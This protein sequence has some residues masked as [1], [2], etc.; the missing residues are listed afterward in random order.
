MKIVM[1]AS[2]FSCLFLTCLMT[3]SGCASPGGAGK[4]TE[5]MN[6][7]S[8]VSISL[9]EFAPGGM[10]ND[11]KLGADASK[12]VLLG[13]YSG[14][15]N[16]SSISTGC[17]NPFM[18]GVCAVFTP[19]LGL[20]TVAGAGVGAVHGQSLGNM[21]AEAHRALAR[22]ISEKPA[23]QSLISNVVDYGTTTANR[24]FYQTQTTETPRSNVHLEVAMLKIDSIEVQGGFFKI[25]STDY[26]VNMEARARLKRTSDG[27][28]LA[29]R[30]YRFLASPRPPKEWSDNDGK[31]LMATIKQGYRQLAEWIVD[32]FFLGQYTDSQPI[33]PT[34]VAPPVRSCG[35]G[36]PC[37]KHNLA[38]V[39][40]DS[41]RPTLRWSFNEPVPKHN[42]K[43]SQATP[44]KINY[45]VRVFLAKQLGTQ[46]TGYFTKPLWPMQPVY[47]R[48][49][50]IGSSHTLEEDLSPCSNYLWTVR[51]IIDQ[52]GKKRATEWAGNYSKKEPPIY[53][54]QAENP[55]FMRQSS[56]PFIT[57][58]PS[59]LPTDVIE[60]DG[61]QFN[62]AYPFS[63]PCQGNGN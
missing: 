32:D 49:G 37:T 5:S 41:L 2:H 24:N 59:N 54:R 38:A 35:G 61:T 25:I 44:S 11:T 29:D 20:M 10:P 6:S 18:A 40:V 22:A 36:Q 7:V 34:P 52:G 30:T 33:F 46:H 62:Y 27:A 4:F 39:P 23:Q 42:A 43:L 57:Q 56:N 45:E 16:V 19:I 9:G 63:T 13:A 48:S 31:L 51:A 47:I 17:K 26:A 1:P 3:L 28:F 50:L 55:Y 14:A 12:D 15:S 58:Q 53:I 60:L 21:E 8:S